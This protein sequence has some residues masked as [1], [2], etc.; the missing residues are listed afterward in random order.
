M[1]YKYF[2]NVKK[3]YCVSLFR[4]L[5]PA[6]VIERLFWQARGVGVQGVVYCEI[7]Y[8]LT[9][10]LLE[11]P[12]GVLAD[13]FGHK[14][15]LAAAG[16]LDAAEFVLLLFARGFWM[17]G[18]AVF[19]AGVGR[20]LYSGSENALLYD[21]LLAEGKQ[22]EFEK[23]LGRLSAID[24]A[25][26]V[27]SALSGGVLANALGF[28]FNYI[29]SACAMGLAFLVI[30]TLR[31]PPVRAEPEDKP[32]Y[33]KQALAVFKNEPLVP[34]YC[35]TGAVLGACLIYLD[36][37]W[38]LILEAVGLPVALFGAVTTLLYLPRIPGSLLAHRLKGRFSYRAILAAILLVNALGYAGVLLTRS[39]LCLVPMAIVSLA[40]GITEPLV[41]GY[42]H[43]HTESRVRATA[44]SFASLGLR[45]LSMPV[46]LVFGYISAKHTIFAGFLPLGMACLAWLVIFSLRAWRG[47]PCARPR[48]RT[49]R[50]KAPRSGPRTS[51]RCRGSTGP[52]PAVNP[53][54]SRG[55][56][57]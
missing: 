48:T 15:L 13:R 49:S 18:L 14:R 46:G 2:G 19:L 51:G 43:H 54:A 12:S 37:F 24:I 1:G 50:W 32:Q 42:L 26:T 29:V 35:L 27:V 40:A 20:A 16:L 34:L 21:S 11:I 52:I 4:S 30:L 39:A 45:L 36:E 33:T 6:Y 8:A 7:I 41:S 9:V 25:G 56:P 10:I 22:G 5:I 31:E 17:F 55:F 44:E 47:S 28:E 57:G 53:G 23:L 38:Q 3:Q